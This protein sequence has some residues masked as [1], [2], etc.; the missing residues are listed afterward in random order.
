MGL[1][2]SA[3]SIPMTKTLKIPQNS[4]YDAASDVRSDAAA[5]V[6]GAAGNVLFALPT[7]RDERAR[8]RVLVNGRPS[9]A[10]ATSG[11]GRTAP[12]S[13]YANVSLSPTAE[14]TSRVRTLS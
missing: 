6:A 7:K 8:A 2:I 14:P 1:L 13:N 4:S 11:R 12:S 10:G 5:A 3:H 9:G